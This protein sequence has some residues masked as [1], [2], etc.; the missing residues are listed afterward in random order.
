MKFVAPLLARFPLPLNPIKA[1]EYEISC[2]G[3]SAPRSKDESQDQLPSVSLL[4]TLPSFIALSAAQVASQEESS[5]T[6]MW[7]RLAADYMAQAVAE[8][9]LVY[10][11]QRPDILQEAFAWGFDES[12]LAAEGTD[13]FAINVMFFDEDAEGTN[14]AWEDIR[15]DR[16]RA[17]RLNSCC[18]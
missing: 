1:V 2:K 16:M 13:E 14:S 11:S 3:S 15:D 4:D 17:V 9:Y 6:E 10:K 5:I 7:M 12:S 8:Q 18:A